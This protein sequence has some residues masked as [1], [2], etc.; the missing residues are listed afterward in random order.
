MFDEKLK[1]R[2]DAEEMATKIEA[3]KSEIGF[4][5]LATSPNINQVINNLSNLDYLNKLGPMQIA[6][7]STTISVYALYLNSEENRYKAYINWCESNLKHLVGT[8]L[9]EVS[10]YGFE[11][12]NSTI[13][14]NEKLACELTEK[15]LIAETKLQSIKDTSL[16][17]E[18][19]C[20]CL[21]NLYFEK[22]RVAKYG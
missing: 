6:E 2:Y 16:K 10:G 4:P 1:N 20:N 5:E 21:R 11:E 17:L 22:N 19:V 7:I 18:F 3:M 14:S 9:G 15:K 12:K 13:R 8:L